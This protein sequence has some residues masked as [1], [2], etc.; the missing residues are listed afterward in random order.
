MSQDASKEVLNIQFTHI[1]RCLLI[2]PSGTGKSETLLSILKNKETL[3]SEKYDYICYFYPVDGMSPIRKDYLKQLT[4]HIPTLEVYE[5]LPQC[6]EV[7]PQAGT[8]LFLLDDLYYDAINSYDFMSFCI[9]GSHQSN[10][11]FFLTCQNLYQNSKYKSSIFRQ[12]TDFIIWPF[13][14][15]QSMLGYLSSQL[16]GDRKFLP[17]CME[18]LKNHIENP[19]ERYLWICMNI[20]DQSPEAYRVRANFVRQN[21]L[22]LMQKKN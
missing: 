21:P 14:G 4:R 19:H 20:A 12:M 7:L 15:D 8:K 10:T 3:F 13:P 6:G 2:A 18:W 17:Q 16:H 22:Y 1:F 5:G 9:Q 11:S